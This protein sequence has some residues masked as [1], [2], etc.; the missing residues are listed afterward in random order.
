MPLPAFILYTAI[1]SA[2]WNGILVGAGYILGDQWEK[3]EGV[4]G[5]LQYAV[6]LAAVAL[7]GWFV[8]S[9]MRSRRGTALRRNNARTRSTTIEPED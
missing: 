3:V 7:V 8:W 4:V 1:G 2:V 6:I 5:Y 9:R